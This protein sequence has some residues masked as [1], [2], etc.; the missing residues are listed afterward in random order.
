MSAFGDGQL[1]AFAYRGWSFLCG[2]QPDG[3]ETFLPV[4]MCVGA[5]PGRQTELPRDTEAYA[6]EAEALRHCEQQAIRW[7]LEHEDTRGQE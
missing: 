3:N 6:T 4:V 2:A 1:H 5:I 7:V